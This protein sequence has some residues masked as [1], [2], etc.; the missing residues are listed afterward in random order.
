MPLK[1][2]DVTFACLSLNDPQGSFID[3]QN[4]KNLPPK[5]YVFSNIFKIHEKI[6]LN[7]RTLFV[8]L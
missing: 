6:L 4:F 1:N 3:D 8:C 2:I 7:P 5:V